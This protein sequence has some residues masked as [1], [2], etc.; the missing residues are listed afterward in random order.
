MLGAGVLAAR[1]RPL[2]LVKGSS[3]AGL[4]LYVGVYFSSALWQLFT[5]QVANA[6]FIGILAGLGVSVVQNMLPG[7]A[8]SASAL[9]TNTTHIGTL[10]S[11]VLVGTVAE[12]YGY[13]SIFLANIVLVL[14]ALALFSAMKVKPD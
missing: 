14:V 11:S 10:L 4:L 5:L 12:F 8:G 13:K 6:I 3:V 9:Y 1:V 7:R 2:A